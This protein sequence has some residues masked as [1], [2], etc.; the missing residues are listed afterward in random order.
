MSL[1]LSVMAYKELKAIFH[2][3]DRTKADQEEDARR[4]SPSAIHW[5]FTIGESPMFCLVTPEVTVLIERIMRR[6]SRARRLWDDLPQGLREHYLRS[7]IIE[8]I[9][10]TNEIEAV[11]STRQEIAD[12]LDAVAGDKTASHQRFREMA[13]LYIAL[14]RGSVDIPDSLEDIRTI[15]D[16][17]TNGEIRNENV[18]DGRLFRAGTVVI[19]DGIK[20][21]HQ[22][23]DSEP[24]INDG[25]TEVLRQS[26]DDDIPSLIRAVAAHFIFEYVHP[27]YDGN[28]RTGRY[29]LELD[30]AQCLSPVA[31]L[32]LCAT[33]A[34]NKT[35][36]YRAF[37]NAENPH[38]K[39][40]ITTFVTEMLGI[41]L[42]AEGRL[43]EDLYACHKRAKQLNTRIQKVMDDPHSPLSSLSQKDY[44]ILFVIAQAATFAVGGEVTLDSIA[45]TLEKSKQ[46]V[47]KVTRQLVD[48]ELIQ[49][50]S[51]RPLRFRLTPTAYTL[52]DLKTLDSQEKPN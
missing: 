27:F 19:T 6:D 26:K 45:Q 39:A 29:L 25:L 30:L 12:V 28:G 1:K 9:H 17:V 38:N 34:D 37:H 49:E 46:Y 36:Y 50:T 22:G 40:D 33:I 14:G 5:D 10:A 16:E 51:K 15:Y 3:Y 11:Y 43:C 47:R 23:V 4:T 2:Q 48:R 44:A 32:S 35:R 13:R 24:R 7:M 21:I 42:E 20:T 18:P 31:W 8:E 41:I 52:L